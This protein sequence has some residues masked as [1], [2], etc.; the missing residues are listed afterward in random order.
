VVSSWKAGPVAGTLPVTVSYVKNN[1]VTALGYM[2]YLEV[3][4][5][6]NLQ[7]NGDQLTFP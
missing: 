2:D 5:R 4:A 3:N 1:P 7:M 6:R